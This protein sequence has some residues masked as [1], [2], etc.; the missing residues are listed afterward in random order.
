VAF[1]NNQQDAFNLRN[2]TES[3][4]QWQSEL[5][6]ATTSIG[7]AE[8]AA[9]EE[10]AALKFKNLSALQEARIAKLDQLI[11]LEDKGIR[12]LA[13]AR[14]TLSDRQFELRKKEIQK[15]FQ[16]AKNAAEELLKIKN[17]KT[18]TSIKKP[19]ASTE[20]ISNASKAKGTSETKKDSIKT[21]ISQSIKKLIG[22]DGT[23]AETVELLSSID[24]KLD[25]ILDVVNNKAQPNELKIPTELT[26]IDTADKVKAVEPANAVKV[27]DATASILSMPAEI[28]A[29]I[30]AATRGNEKQEPPK[31]NSKGLDEAKFVEELLAILREGIEAIVATAE[32]KLDDIKAAQETKDYLLA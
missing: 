21:V 2:D 28:V 23:T 14:L 8:V 5:D 26:K 10:L 32:Q 30:E 15:E 6:K 16:L 4:K 24:E 3:L 31:D 20:D 1:E 13:K 17:K 25:S 22:A 12:E 19:A 18:Q 9:E 27:N 7:A 29:A 11:A